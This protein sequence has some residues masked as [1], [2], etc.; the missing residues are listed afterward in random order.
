MI[1][2]DRR[3]DPVDAREERRPATPATGMPPAAAMMLGLQSAAGNRAVGALLGGMAVAGDTVARA[4]DTS[5][6]AG[7]PAPAGFADGLDGAGGGSPL[8]DGVRQ[9]LESGTGTSLGDVRVHVGGT[10]PGLAAQVGARAFTLGRDIYFGQGTYAPDSP[11]GYHLLAHEVAH[12]V[13]QSRAPAGGTVTVGAVDSPAERQADAA[14]DQLSADSP[15]AVAAAPVAVR[16]DP[17]PN[18]TPADPP[19]SA[20]VCGPE[21]A[22]LTSSDPQVNGR[23]VAE[24]G[25]DLQARAGRY[26]R[27]VDHL[28]RGTEATQR[29]EREWYQNLGLMGSFIDLFNSAPATD[30][31]RWDAVYP[32]WDSTATALDAVIAEPVT[33]TNLNTAGQAASNAFAAFR[34][35]SALDQQCRS[36]YQSYLQGF[37]HAAEN[38]LTVTEITRDVAFGAAVA[39]AV[40]V[41]AP[42]VAAGASTF[43]SGTLGLGATGTTIFTYG[44][45]ATAMG[46]MGAGIEGAGRGVGTFAAQSAGAL[47]DLVNGSGQAADNF[48]FSQVGSQ[49]WDGMKQGF[50]DGVLAF[51]GAQAERAIAGPASYALR[52]FLGP[53]N[54]ALS[55][56]IIRR[57]LARAISGGA[58]GSVIGALQAGYRTAVAGG[59]IHQI[60]AAMAQGF[61]IG[62][63][64]GITL[65]AVGGGLEARAANQVRQRVA[66]ALRGAAANDTGNAE[67]LYQGIMAQLEANPQA[68]T[69]A[70]LRAMLPDVWKALRDPDAIAS[71]AADIWLEERLLNIMAPPTDRYGQA[72]TALSRRTGAPIVILQRGQ[73]FNPMQFYENVVVQGNRFLDLSVLDLSP[74]HGATTHMMQDLVVDR[75]LAGQGSGLR[76]DQLRALFQGA[77]GSNGQAI[78]N[79]I[80]V[81]FF[82]SFGQGLNQPEVVYP[83]LQDALTGLR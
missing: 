23:T 71:V 74:Q 60:E 15:A 5:G 38:V 31:S 12:T 75:V 36:E 29:D 65:S 53:N 7:G 35:A 9:K 82:D 72:V 33:T 46:L 26:R 34:E 56:M 55:A 18:F 40:V 68:G 47:A 39:I 51:A 1:E 67:I 83:V 17:A 81:E 45:T 13:Q 44:S 16:R 8:P 21:E 62:L 59:D 63:G 43:A 3:S 66:D 54:A 10:A 73:D 64:A 69:N 61:A 37:T 24:V 28:R 49:T 41:A 79:D 32:L 25:Q 22:R 76:A 14:A 19:G 48:D 58:T 57:A 70:Q 27:A 4:P 80:W 52:N 11:D 78:G 2:R 20:L 42:V 50:V 6:V 77:M 30:P